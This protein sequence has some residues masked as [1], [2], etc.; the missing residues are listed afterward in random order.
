MRNEILKL[1]AMRG[2]Y[3]LGRLA[4]RQKD[5]TTAEREFRAAMTSQPDSAYGYGVLANFYRRQN[6]WDD[7]FAV[8]DALIA[9]RP[10]LVVTHANW[11]IYAALS[12]QHLDRGERELKQYLANV[13]K[14]A[15]PTTLSV[16]HWRLGQIYEKTSRAELAR[17]EFTEAVKINPQNQDAK[18]S[19]DA[20]K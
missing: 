10:D 17:A 2:H 14:D 16:V 18:K 1:S 13:P 15:S 8:W 6:R 20:L 9:A 4:E 7:A 11:G 19:L 5:S 12:G 3:S